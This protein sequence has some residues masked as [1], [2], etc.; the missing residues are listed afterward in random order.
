MNAHRH[1][2]IWRSFILRVSEEELSEA[3][4]SQDV[5]KFAE[6]MEI[7]EEETV[8]FFRLEN[9]GYEKTAAEL[10]AFAES[11]KGMSDEEA[12]NTSIKKFLEW[13]RN[14]QQE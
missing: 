13:Q 4:L 8:E 11:L 12:R 14:R 1:M 5:V 9:E 2:E 7:S 3:K 10:R 6:I